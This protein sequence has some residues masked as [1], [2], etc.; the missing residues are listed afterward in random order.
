MKNFKCKLGLHDWKYHNNIT[1]QCLEC[2]IIQIKPK[3]FF[4]KNTLDSYFQKGA[5]VEPPNHNGVVTIKKGTI[6]LVCDGWQILNDCTRVPKYYAHKFKE[7]TTIYP[8]YEYQQ[9][10]QRM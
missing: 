10:N 5:K 3:F 6:I 9:K 2:G 1:K 8:S 7:D 4:W